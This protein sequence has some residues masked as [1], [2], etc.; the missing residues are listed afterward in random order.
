MRYLY[1]LNKQYIQSGDEPM[2]DYDPE[3]NYV[4]QGSIEPGIYAIPTYAHGVSPFSVGWEIHCTPC[5]G[6]NVVTEYAFNPGDGCPIVKGEFTSPPFGGHKI[7]II[8]HTYIYEKAPQSKY[9]GVTFYPDITVKTKS[10][11]I[12]S[13]NHNRQRS[14]EVWVRDGRFD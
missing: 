8:P 13:L 11:A 7:A 2:V 5:S 4:P 9:T 6:D 14:M 10:G 1:I 3:A 12:K